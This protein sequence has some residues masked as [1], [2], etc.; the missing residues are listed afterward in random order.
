MSEK[1]V[2]TLIDYINEQYKPYDIIVLD[3]KEHVSDTCFMKV[4]FENLEV[5]TPEERNIHTVYSFSGSTQY[6]ITDEEYKT[7]VILKDVCRFFNIRGTRMV[8]DYSG[9]IPLG[10]HYSGNKLVLGAF[11]KDD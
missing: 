9:S 7:N 8:L 6:D 11:L 2:K 10:K 1:F 4:I 3:P 5:G